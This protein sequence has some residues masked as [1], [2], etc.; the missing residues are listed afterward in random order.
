MQII[1]VIKSDRSV[2]HRWLF[3]VALMRR[4]KSAFIA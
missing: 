4:E 3:I 1:N 2:L